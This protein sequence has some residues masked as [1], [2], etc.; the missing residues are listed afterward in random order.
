MKI[1]ATIV[2]LVVGLIGFWAVD[3][4]RSYF[5]FD[6]PH[7]IDLFDVAGWVLIGGTIGAVLALL[8]RIRW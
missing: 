6:P 5:G 8:E 1:L 4:T 7:F 2:I 3:A